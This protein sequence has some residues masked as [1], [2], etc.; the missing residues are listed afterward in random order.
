MKSCN[1]L[2]RLS[3]LLFF[4]SNF[5]GYAAK[6][7]HHYEAIS[8]SNQQLRMKLMRRRSL[9]TATQT[10]SG[11]MSVC[12]RCAKTYKHKWTLKRH[13][14]YECGQIPRFCC[15]YCDHRSRHKSDLIKH[16][17]HRHRGKKVVYYYINT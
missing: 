11:S 15:C 13:M 3:F 10:S 1:F 5:T 6:S 9:L 8:N 17:Q 16:I 14:I 12:P 7:Q 4:W 2:I